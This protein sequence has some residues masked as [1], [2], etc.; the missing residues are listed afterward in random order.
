MIMFCTC[1]L[2]SYRIYSV[3]SK[4]SLKKFE[5]YL[6]FRYIFL[7]KNMSAEVIV[8]ESSNTLN[9]Q[10]ICDTVNTR[11]WQRSNKQKFHTAFLDPLLKMEIFVFVTVIQFL[12]TSTIVRC[13]IIS[14]SETIFPG[15]PF[16]IPLAKV[17][18]N[19]LF[20]QHYQ[21]N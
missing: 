12:L 2:V 17:Q 20:I 14:I 6:L 21:S 9:H 4:I 7:L 16:I 19:I 1:R 3:K 8:A 5:R 11:R 15:T 13:D 18:A 10:Q